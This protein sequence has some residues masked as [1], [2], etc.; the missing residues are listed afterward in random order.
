MTQKRVMNARKISIKETK[1]KICK[2]TQNDYGVP[3]INL[4][5]RMAYGCFVTWDVN[6]LV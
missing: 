1:D 6:G 2:I 3:G 4:A 5:P